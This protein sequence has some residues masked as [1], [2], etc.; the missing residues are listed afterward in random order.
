MLQ[1][2]IVSPHLAEMPA[3]PSHTGWTSVWIRTIELHQS[4]PDDEAACLHQ[5]SQ[6]HRRYAANSQLFRRLPPFLKVP[7]NLLSKCSQ[8]LSKETRIRIEAMTRKVIQELSN[9]WHLW[10]R[11]SLMSYTIDVSSTINTNHVPLLLQEMLQ[12]R[13]VLL[14]RRDIG[15]E[16]ECS[17]QSDSLS[18]R[19]SPNPG[20][21]IA[22]AFHC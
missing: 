7:P 21:V 8:L 20:L 19:N 1:L 18:G 13:W 2:L 5:G 6:P 4:Q 9:D 12:H 14:Y 16:R 22:F 15:K 11:C 3:G 10:K 17:Q